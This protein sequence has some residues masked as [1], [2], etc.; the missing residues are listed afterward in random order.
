ML[1]ASRVGG[2]PL[3]RF[4]LPARRAPLTLAEL[5]SRLKSPGELMRLAQSAGLVGGANR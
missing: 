3:A 5:R 1:Y 2:N 4:L